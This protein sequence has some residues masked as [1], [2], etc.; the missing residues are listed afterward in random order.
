MIPHFRRICSVHHLP[1]FLTLS[2]QKFPVILFSLVP[3]TCSYPYP[4]PHTPAR[5]HRRRYLNDLIPGGVLH[6]L[7][8]PSMLFPM[9]VN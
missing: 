2:C 8:Q 7:R 4:I 3:F 6:V 1:F 5:V 9:N